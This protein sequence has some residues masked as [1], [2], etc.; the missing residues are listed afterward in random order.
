VT[1]GTT[2]YPGVG[3]DEAMT[4]LH[5][6]VGQITARWA[7]VEESLFHVFVVALAGTWLAGDFRPYR[8]VFFAFNSFDTKMRM[9]DSAMQARFGADENIMADWKEIRKSLRGFAEI[10]NK[11]AHTIPIPKGSSDPT[12]RATV[13]LV[14]PFWKTVLKEDFDEAGYSVDELW[15]ALA[16]Y[17]GYHPR[18]PNPPS[19]PSDQ[20]GYRVQ[21]FAMQLDPNARP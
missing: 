4:E 8:A 17:W 10:R 6:L 20:L 5:N 11:V 12:A 15:Q 2:S 3:V 16:P 7:S 21:Q 19:G 13:R 14:P 9:V 18:I 1:N